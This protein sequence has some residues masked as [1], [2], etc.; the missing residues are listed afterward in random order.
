MSRVSFPTQFPNS[1]LEPFLATSPHTPSYNCIA[2]AFGDD[3]KWYWPDPIHMYYWPLSVPREITIDAF[4]AL[5][6][7]ISYMICA[8][9]EYEE[10][11]EKIAIFVDSQGIPTHAARQLTN[12]SWT[13]KLGQ[14]ID[15]Q[16]SIM[17]MEGGDYGNVSVYM[18]RQK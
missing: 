15:V 1:Q 17:A 3:T 2:W 9:G 12:G 18:E 11:K 10:G 6:N 5:Y 13:S 14:H 4:I 8:S 16:H 7:S